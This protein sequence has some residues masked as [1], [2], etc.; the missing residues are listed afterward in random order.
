MKMRE[1]AASLDLV[2]K[3]GVQDDDNGLERFLAATR[4]QNFLAPP[5]AHRAFPLLEFL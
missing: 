1:N 4:R 2:K 3:Y 5:R